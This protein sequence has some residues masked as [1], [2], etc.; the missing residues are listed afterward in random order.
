MILLVVT[1][2]LA[3]ACCVG[4][5]T[6]TPVVAGRCEKLVMGTELG[7]KR[8]FG[9]WNGQ[10]ESGPSSLQQSSLQATL[11]MAYRWSRWGQFSV[12]LPLRYGWDRAGELSD[13][14]GGLSDLRLGVILDPFEEAAPSAGAFGLPTPVL[15]LGL[16]LPTGRSWQG[17]L[18]PLLSDV[19]GQPG[20]ALSLGLR[21]ERT[22]GLYPWGISVEGELPGE[23]SLP[24]LWSTGGMLGRYLGSNW[25]IAG[26][27]HYS[28]TPALSEGGGTAE[29]GL[30]LRLV[31][32]QRL[33]WR[34]WL[35]VEGAI[36]APMLGHNKV[37]QVGLSGGLAL[38]R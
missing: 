33:R 34:L 24:M 21:L 9:Y 1:A 5:T 7:V 10:G 12:A 18:S 38:V 27:L 23:A 31:Y 8:S 16:R 2:A 6:G 19:T 25:T 17:S 3:G 36:P 22:L 11:G 20:L 13:E 28:W 26:S 14:G 4:S 30:G 15:S 35:G 37:Q 29:T 32:G